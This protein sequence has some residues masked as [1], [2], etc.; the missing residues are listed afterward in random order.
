[1]AAAEAR[2]ADFPVGMKV[3]VVD[4]DPTCLVV[5]KRM[6]LECRYDG[7]QLPR[8]S[9]PPL[10]SLLWRA[11]R[12]LLGGRRLIASLFLSVMRIVIYVCFYFVPATVFICLYFVVR[13]GAA[14]CDS[15]APP[16]NSREI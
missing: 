8:S 15:H 4:D 2:G 13:E 1:M 7:E 14:L 16:V 11:S 3:L 9:P 6:L 12:C 10:G 5:L